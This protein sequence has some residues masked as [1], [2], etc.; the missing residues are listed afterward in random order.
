MSHEIFVL[1]YHRVCERQA[2]TACWFERG[3]AVTPAHFEAHMSWLRPR[4]RFV[5]LDEALDTREANDAI[6]R[7]VVSFDD[8]YRDALLATRM[9]IPVTV[10]AVANHTG[11][12]SEP[13]WFD[14]YYD[15]LHRARRRSGVPFAA[16]SLQS[17]GNAPPIDDDLRWWVRGPLKERLQSLPDA[18]RGQVL[19]A[20]AKALDAKGRTTPHE[21]YLTCS[22]L[23]DL[24]AAGHCIGGHGATHTR[25]TLLDDDALVRELAASQDLLGVVAPSR[26]PVFCYPDGAHDARVDDATRRVGFVAA[27]TVEKGIMRGA[28]NVFAIPRL[29]M[30]DGL[31]TSSGWPAEFGML[32]GLVDSEARR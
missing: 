11:A 5:T 27:C 28:T 2:Q 3:T 17:V 25:L 12:A 29:L 9:N 30:R 20:L 32:P 8:G 7:C 16:L 13:L 21:L 26:R 6:P 1:M 4:V 24:S 22:E 14:R 31:P 19:D 18:Q 23:R 10:F 15:I